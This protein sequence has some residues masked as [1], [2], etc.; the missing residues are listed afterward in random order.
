MSADGSAHQ[1]KVLATRCGGCG[2]GCPTILETGDADALV[3]VGQ[4]KGQALDNDAV[5]RYVGE[6]E[7]AV[8]IPKSLLLEAAKA[9]S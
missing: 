5:A 7:I 6:G 3:V 1:Y 2:C 9:L 4:L 8:L